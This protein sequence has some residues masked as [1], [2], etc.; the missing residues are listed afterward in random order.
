MVDSFK[1]KPAFSVSVEKDSFDLTGPIAPA[2][3]SLAMENTELNTYDLARFPDYSF[4]VTGQPYRKSVIKRGP[5]SGTLVVTRFTTAAG[6]EAFKLYD[7]NGK[8]TSVLRRSLAQALNDQELIPSLEPLAGFVTYFVD[9]SGQ[10]YCLKPSGILHKLNLDTSA[11]TER[12]VLYDRKG[13]RRTLTRAAL[14]RLANQ[15]P[16]HKSI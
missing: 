16:G 13:R 15:F 9:L 6:E 11:Q 8:R 4:D 10:P 12:F 14:I 3:K 2:K 1:S 7:Q 5:K